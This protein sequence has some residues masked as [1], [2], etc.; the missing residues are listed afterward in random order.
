[1]PP[2]T[3]NATITMLQ[4]H[5]RPGKLNINRERSDRYD[6]NHVITPNNSPGEHFQRTSTA[7][8]CRKQLTCLT[9][10]DIHAF[11]FDDFPV[12]IIQSSLCGIVPPSAGRYKFP[13]VL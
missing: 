3:T 13:T 4:N 5:W 9:R 6:F 2:I 12:N 10:R 8:L 11:T 1:M 7:R